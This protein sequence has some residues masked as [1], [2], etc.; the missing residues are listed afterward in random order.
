MQQ[1]MQMLQLTMRICAIDV[2]H[3]QIFQRWRLNGVL[4]RLKLMGWRVDWTSVITWWNQLQV[5]WVQKNEKDEIVTNK[6][7]RHFRKIK[8]L[9]NG[10]LAKVKN[11]LIENVERTP[12]KLI[13]LII[14]ISVKSHNSK[15]KV[16]APTYPVD[17]NTLQQRRKPAPLSNR[18]PIVKTS[19]YW[20]ASHMLTV[21][22]T[23][24]SNGNVRNILTQSLCLLRCM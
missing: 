7:S 11:Q 9:F 24:Q 17:S 22:F 19:V 23:Q 18:F 4:L 15:E 14:E 10:Y 16:S 8:V 2:H 6:R 5:P 21:S 1:D 13:N 3:K 20:S 12:K